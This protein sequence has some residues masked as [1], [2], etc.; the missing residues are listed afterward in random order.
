MLEQSSGW[1]CFIAGTEMLGQVGR[2]TYQ[3]E[4][5]GEEVLDYQRNEQVGEWQG[6]VDF[7]K[8]NW[9]EYIKLIYPLIL[10]K[11]ILCL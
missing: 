1:K 2:F 8:W 5:K 7:Q 3:V 4:L 11:Y 9:F 10:P 6:L